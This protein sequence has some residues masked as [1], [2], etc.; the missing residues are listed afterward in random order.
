MWMLALT[1]ALILATGLTGCGGTGAGRLARGDSAS[2]RSSQYYL[3]LGDS[4]SVGIQ[5]S[6]TGQQLETRQGYVN[7]VWAALDRRIP[8]LRLI[9][10]G[11]PGDATPQV[12]TGQ[13]NTAAAAAYHCDRAG[14][15]QLTAALGFIAAHRSGVRVISIDIGANDLIACITG[16]AVRRGMA[17][18]AACVDQVEQTIAIDLPKILGPLR[19]A[20]APGTALVAG[21]IYDP[22]LVGLLNGDA[23]LRT[24]GR[25][26]VGVVD[27]LNAEITSAAAQSGFAT[28]NLAEIF[29][30]DNRTEVADPAAGRRVPRNLIVLCAL[31]YL[32]TAKPQGPNIH[33]NPAG[34]RAIAQTYE[35]QLGGL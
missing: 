17:S 19:A 18:I 11:C 30:T 8:H 7:D 21:E 2:S 35:Q 24:I 9:Q 13:G 28:A 12:L 1:V 4:L 25:E 33:P 32:C 16:A 14:G 6:A 29:Q 10:L 15:S 3:A 27:K 34:Y 23:T 20:A 22:F 5:P 26:S 31:T